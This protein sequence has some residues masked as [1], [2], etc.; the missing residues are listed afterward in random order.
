MKHAQEQKLH[1]TVESL[2]RSRAYTRLQ[3]H[4]EDGG[5]ELVQKT[6]NFVEYTLQ[7][8]E[9]EEDLHKP[10]HRNIRSF[11]D[12]TGEHIKVLL[13]TFHGPLWAEQLVK[14]LRVQT[15]KHLL[16]LALRVELKDFLPDRCLAD[17]RSSCQARYE[18]CQAQSAPN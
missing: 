11:S 5:E 8:R 16:C 3:E 18:A 15:L 14:K 6:L 9:S 4:L 17:L 2:L 10:L 1:E 7:Q 13:Q 12:L